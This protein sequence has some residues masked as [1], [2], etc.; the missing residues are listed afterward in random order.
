MV[1][2]LDLHGVRH[3]DVDREVIR[4]VENAW[5]CGCKLQFVTGHSPR[6]KALVTK[7]L[8]EYN[9]KCREGDLLGHNK[10]FLITED[11]I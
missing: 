7:T 9:L 4:F 11:E 5:G 6:M 10:N 8:A 2:I 3:A 1:K